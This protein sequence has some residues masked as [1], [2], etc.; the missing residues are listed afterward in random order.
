[1]KNTKKRIIHKA[2]ELYNERGISNVSSKTIA[3]ELGISDGNLR[4]HYKNK[5]AILK[6]ILANMI[7][8]L[9]VIEKDFDLMD[10]AIDHTFFFNLF[11][12]SYVITFDYR[13]LFID[14]VYLSKEF[15]GYFSIFSKYIEHWRSKFQELFDYLLSEGI[16]DS[17]YSKEQYSRLYDQ[18][19]MFSNSWYF[20]KEQ[21]PEKSLDYFAEIG[22]SIFTPYWKSSEE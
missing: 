9:L 17:K 18:I 10:T 2:Q 3:L 6:V 20:Y 7:E 12:N 1:M 4:Y 14:Q 15:P 19:S 21:D 16:F 22:A 13:A 11:K 5:E 8:D